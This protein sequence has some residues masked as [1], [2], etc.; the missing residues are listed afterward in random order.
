ML[1]TWLLLGV[2]DEIN[3]PRPFRVAQEW[4]IG[5]TTRPCSCLFS[6]SNSVP[7]SSLRLPSVF[8]HHPKKPLCCREP[9]LIYDSRRWKS[10]EVIEEL[11]YSARFLNKFRFQ[12]GLEEIVSPT[13]WCLLPE[14]MSG[15][16]TLFELEGNKAF[17]TFDMHITALQM[18]EL[19]DVE[20]RQFGAFEI[21]FFFFLFQ[22]SCFGSEPCCKGT[23][24]SQQ[25]K[26]SQEYCQSTRYYIRYR[27]HK[28]YADSL[29]EEPLFCKI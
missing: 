26:R 16:R 7:V 17:C 24:L 2:N 19:R 20:L 18:P 23:C 14:D 4:A 29:Y 8:R 21:A 28:F 13:L 15:L 9:S 11:G 6:C 22:S 25:A 3:V 12:H 5:T 27:W 10:V 1:K